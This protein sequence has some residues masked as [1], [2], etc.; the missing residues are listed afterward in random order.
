MQVKE[1]MVWIRAIELVV[2]WSRIAR[3]LSKVEEE[4]MVVDLLLEEGLEMIYIRQRGSRLV[5]S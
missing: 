3:E 1:Q 4:Q 5:K 2:E